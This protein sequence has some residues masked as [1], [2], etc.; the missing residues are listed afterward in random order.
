MASELGIGSSGAASVPAAGPRAGG[1]ALG[2]TAT[3]FLPL[4]RR[5]RA[6]E[7]QLGAFF[8]LEWVTGKEHVKLV[9][10]PHDLAYL[11]SCSRC[12]IV[13]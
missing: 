1:E 8:F 10:Q 13:A 5:L 3:L 9:C 12:L 4:Q 11:L 2:F 7:L 6:A